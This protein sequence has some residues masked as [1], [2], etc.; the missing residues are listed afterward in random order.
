MFSVARFAGFN[1]FV[2]RYPASMCRGGA[3]LKRP[4]RE[5]QSLTNQG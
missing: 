2:Y 4:L 1:Y 3:I 5:L